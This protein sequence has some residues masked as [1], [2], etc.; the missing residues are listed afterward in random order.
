MG[1]G[2]CSRVGNGRDGSMLDDIPG[3][4]CNTQP[5]IKAA[6]FLFSSPSGAEHQDSGARRAITISLF[7]STLVFMCPVNAKASSP[8]PRQKKHF[9]TRQIKAFPL[10]QLK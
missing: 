2:G 9:R 7:K 10:W 5:D 1:V 8:P 6:L 3:Q 4:E